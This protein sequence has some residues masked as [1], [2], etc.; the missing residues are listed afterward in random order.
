M[1]NWMKSSVALATFGFINLVLFI[2]LS[3]PFIN[4]MDVI[5]EESENLG[6]E[7]DVNPFLDMWKT[8]FGLTF[9]LSMFGLA[10]WFFLGAHRKEYEESW[11]E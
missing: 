9:V 8:V 5:S 11:R 10:V 1:A 2:I 7:D 6:I 4:I 3:T